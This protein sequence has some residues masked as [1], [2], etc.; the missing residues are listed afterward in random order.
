MIDPEFKK[1]WVAALRSG[2]YKQGKYKLRNSPRAQY[3][4]LGVACDISAKRGIGDWHNI[5]YSESMRFA[6]ITDS[7]TSIPSPLRVEL[8]I[9]PDQQQTLID[10]NDEQDKSFDEIADYIETNL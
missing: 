2:Y 1:E 6:F 3:C 9:T 10:L 8:G 4:C 5:D 7:I